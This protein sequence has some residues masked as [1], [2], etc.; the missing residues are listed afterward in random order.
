MAR[1][2]ILIAIAASTLFGSLTAAR[3]ALVS[4]DYVRGET[5]RSESSESSAIDLLSFKTHSRLRVLVDQGVEAR[6]KDI[7]GGFELLL[8]GLTLG[9]MGAPLGGEETFSARFKG[10]SDQRL[11][12]LTIRE[13]NEGVILK[14]R[15]KFPSGAFAPATPKMEHFEYRENSPARFVLDFWSKPGPTVAQKKRLD[16]VQERADEKKRAEEVS[17]ARADD[18]KR[19]EAIR[20]E[21]ENLTRFCHAHLT[22]GS[23]VFLEFAAVREEFELGRYLVQNSPEEGYEWVRPDENEKDGAYLRLALRLHHEKNHAL[24]LRTIDFF[25][26]DFP[27]SSYRREMHF[28]KANARLALGMKTEAD[29]DFEEIRRNS[30]DSQAAL[31]AGLYAAIRNQGSTSPLQA[32]D[33]WLWLI[34]HH[35]EHPNAWVFHLMAAENLTEL[36]QTER[37]AKEY[38]W[39]AQNAPGKM[40]RVEGAVRIGDLF[41]Q[42]RQYERSLAAYFQAMNRF[43]DE[44]TKFPA[45]QLNRAESL[46]W[47]GQY[48]RAGEAYQ[49]FI[50]AYPSHPGGWRAEYRLG[51]IFGRKS[52]VASQD[53]SR[54]HFL[55]TINRYPTSPGAEL[56]RLRLL[57]CGDHGG[58]DGSTAKDYLTKRVIDF[59]GRGEILL[60]RWKD[61]LALSQVRSMISLGD[62]ATAIDIAIRSVEGGVPT[63]PRKSILAMLR[64]LFRRT[65]LDHLAAGRRY[66][67]L[68]FHEEKI[69]DFPL[70]RSYRDDLVNP[71][72]LLELSSAATELGMGALATSLMDQYHRAEAGYRGGERQIA[73]QDLNQEGKKP[74]FSPGLDLI[75]EKANRAWVEAKALWMRSGFEEPGKLEALLASIPEESPHAYGKHVLLGAL[76][77]KT[78]VSAESLNELVRARLLMPP[79]EVS[80]PGEVYRLEA[81]IGRLQERSGDMRASLATL[82]GLVQQMTAQTQAPKPVDETANGGALGLI[83]QLG[84]GSVPSLDEILRT[85]ASIQTRLERWVDASGTWGKL[86]ELTEKKAADSDTKETSLQVAARYRF[87]RA[88]ALTRA[89][90]AGDLDAAKADLDLIIQSSKDE[91]WTRLARESLAIGVEVA[92]RSIASDQS[93]KGQ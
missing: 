86:I 18:R 28:L 57:P 54:E 51:E 29:Q 64:S 41:Y 82:S 21:E 58:F 68:K 48:D 47:L 71:D 3:A 9:D 37:A 52:D 60:D 77:E 73:S 34:R 74:Q 85:Q 87:E 81:W 59:D 25:E 62:H 63:E 84:S 49:E 36:R 80:V 46:Y 93:K 70:I 67:A 72:Y 4:A 42:R 89:G 23:D 91:V 2:L 6:W 43:P 10:L 61:Y 26:K 88:R 92:F 78:G 35:P 24:A 79:S 1:R 75:L 27:K 15:W 17:Q 45:I 19:R 56:A 11:S 66:E 22:E 33:G 13:T 20:Q 31:S 40:Y 32:L 50:K 55:G 8:K 30:P 44:T 16:A 7:S 39:V 12:G 14:G 83:A 65:V 5:P 38:Q 90:R 53:R 69:R 76:K